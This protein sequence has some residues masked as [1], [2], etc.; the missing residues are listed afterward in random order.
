MFIGLRLEHRKENMD[1]AVIEGVT[2]ALKQTFELIQ[3]L[4]VDIKEIRITG[5]GAK[6]SIWAQMIS[7]IMNVKVS[8]IAIEEGPALG[9]AILAM[10]GNGTYSSVEEA[11][12]LLIQENDLY[13]PNETL[14][15]VYINKYERFQKLYPIVKKIYDLK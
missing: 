4:G 1:R 13:Y 6:S 15:K 3:K 7:N 8:T 9:A 12:Q 11:C 10:V 14:S 5:G 2:F